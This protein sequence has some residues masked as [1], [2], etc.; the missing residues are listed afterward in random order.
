LKFRIFG[1]NNYEA[2]IKLKILNEKNRNMEEE[3]KN[4]KFKLQQEK[5]YFLNYILLKN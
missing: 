4:L 1:I 5:V 3:I 2:E